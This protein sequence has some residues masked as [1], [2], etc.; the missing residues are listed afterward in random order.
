MES[1]AVQTLV[2]EQSFSCSSSRPHSS[3]PGSGCRHIVTL[4]LRDK[5]SCHSQDSKR[6]QQ[7]AAACSL[8]HI[9]HGIHHHIQDLKTSRVSKDERADWDSTVGYQSTLNWKG[10]YL[11][12][13]PHMNCRRL[14][15][16]CDNSGTKKNI[17]WCHVSVGH[18]SYKVHM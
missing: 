1:G 13:T 16:Y 6:E 8:S 17:A 12:V 9:H 11:S 15:I 5:E 7:R 18:P 10:S 3:A 4:Y 2:W 14:L